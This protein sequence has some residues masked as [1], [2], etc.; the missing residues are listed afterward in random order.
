V[1]RAACLEELPK[2]EQFCIGLLPQALVPRRN[3]FTNNSATSDNVSDI[4]SGGGAILT[5]VAR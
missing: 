3:T 1:Q 2:Q 5:A 4:V